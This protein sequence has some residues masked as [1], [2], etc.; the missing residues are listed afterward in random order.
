MF[1]VAG[2]TTAPFESLQQRLAVAGLQTPSLRI[3]GIKVHRLRQKLRE[4][5]GYCCSRDPV[6][7]TSLGASIIEVGTGPGLGIE[8]ERKELERYRTDLITI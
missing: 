5:M 1:G 3:T 4:P 8:V 2:L 6:G 7:M